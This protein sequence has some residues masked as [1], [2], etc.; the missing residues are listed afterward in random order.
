MKGKSLKTVVISNCIKG[1]LYNCLISSGFY[2]TCINTGT[3]IPRE[4][5]ITIVG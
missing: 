3:I 4:C 2:N 5:L 1:S